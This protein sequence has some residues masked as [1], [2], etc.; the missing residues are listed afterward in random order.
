MIW[1]RKFVGLG[2]ASG[3]DM[4]RREGKGTDRWRRRRRRAAGV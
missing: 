4:G 3:L 2:L 1:R